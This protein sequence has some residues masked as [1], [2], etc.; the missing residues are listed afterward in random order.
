MELAVI[1]KTCENATKL[2]NYSFDYND[3]CNLENLCGLTASYK[4]DSCVGNF[5]FFNKRLRYRKLSIRKL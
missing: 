5:N 4:I 3:S 1:I 2:L